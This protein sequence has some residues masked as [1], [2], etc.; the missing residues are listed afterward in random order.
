MVELN[1]SERQPRSRG[2]AMV[3]Y[4]LILVLLALAFGIAIA[5]TGPAIGNV[6]CNVVHNL[7]GNSASPQGGECGSTAPDLIAEGGNPPLFWAT[8]TWVAGHPQGETPFPTPI[9]R[10]ASG[11]SGSLPTNTPSLTFTPS[12]T[13]T[14]TPSY[15]PTNTPTPTDSATPGPSPTNGDIAFSLPHV[16]QVS[17]PEWWR[18]DS[19]D[20]TGYY[21]WSV[22]WYD[23]MSVSLNAGGWQN[24][25]LSSP[26][27]SDS[28]LSYD[29]NGI[30]FDWGTGIPSGSGL[31]GNNTW[32]GDFN[33]TL[34]VAQTALYQFDL[35]ANDYANVYIDGGNP[36]VWRASTGSASATVA[37]NAGTHNLRILYADNSGSA[38]LALTVT[39]LTVNPDDPTSNPTTCTWGRT[40]GSND[41]V[42]VSWQ[43]DENPASDSWPGGQTCYLELRGYVDLM[44]DLNP[45]LSFW[46][47]W[48][49]AAGSGV[50]VDLQIGN[51]ETDAFGFLDRS[52]LN[53]QT[54][55]LHGAGTS[56]YNWTREQIDIRSAAPPLTNDWVTFRFRI[57]SGAG[58]TPVRWYIDDLQL[59]NDPAPTTTFTV[60]DTWDL[61]SSDQMDDFIFDGDSN[62]TIAA[63][64]SLPNTT[65]SWRWDL[66]STHAHSG[67]SW[68]DSPTGNYQDHSQAASGQQRVHYLE[69]KY[70]IDLTSPPLTD[71]DGD[72]GVPL[73]TFW[74]AFDIALNAS[75]RVQ[76]T[77]D[78]N[79]STPD[80][81]I[82]VPAEGVLIDY[83][84]PTGSNRTNMV[85][86][87][88]EIDLTNITNL[89]ITNFRLRFAL[90]VDGA[91]TAFAD[92]WYIDDIKIERENP[93]PFFAYPF[94]DDAENSVDTAEWWEAIGGEW[95]AT[96]ERGGAN[97]SPT[98]YADSPLANYDPNDTQILQLH[99]A[100][101]LLNDTPGNTSGGTAATSPLLTFWHQ[102]NVQ[103]GVTFSVDL[104]TPGD[105]WNQIWLYDSAT[106][107][108]F[109]TQS[110]WERVEI[111][112]I[113]AL[114]TVTG[115][116]WANIVAN[117]DSITDDDDIKVRFVFAPGSATPSDGV[118]VDEINIK[119]APGMEHRLWAVASGGNGALVDSIESSTNFAGPWQLRWYHGGTWG[120]TS[121][122]GYTRTGSQALTD[123]PPA[124]STNYSANTF[125]VM[126]LIPIIDMTSTAAGS[127][128][129][130]SFWTRYQIGSDDTFRVEIAT[131]NAA[132]TT[133]SYNK[134]GG[135]SAW[136]AQPVMLDNTASDP[137]TNTEVDTW[138]RGQVDLT[139]FIGQKIRVRIVANVPNTTNQADGIYVDEVAFTYSPRLI[140]LPYAETGQSLVNWISEGTWGLAQNYYPGTGTSASDFGSTSWV[141]TYFDC[142]NLG[143]SS[144]NSTST[145][146]QML[147]DQTNLAPVAPFNS[148][149][150]TQPIGPEILADINFDWG[151]TGRPLGGA[152]PDP[153]FANT[154]LARWTRTVTLSPGTYS[155]STVSDD[156]VNLWIDDFTDTDIIGSSAAASGGGAN[157]RYIIN[158][159][160]DHS[161]ALDYGSFTVTNTIT[162]VLTLE[163][164]ENG[165]SAKIILNATRGSYSFTDSPNTPYTACSPNDGD[166]C[167][168]GLTVVK[169][170]Y[171]GNSSL[172][173]N[174]Y[175]SLPVSGTPSLAY[176][177]L[178]QLPANN[179]FYVEV[180]TDGG[181]TWTTIGSET[182]SGTTRLPPG[183]YWEQR[184]VSLSAYSGQAHM[185]IRFRLDTRGSGGTT[186]DGVYVADIRVTG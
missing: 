70:P 5:A 67:L 165:G 87:P 24:I 20:F 153:A 12:E 92:G 138:Q 121:T 79:D 35:T 125:S 179:F 76:Y 166:T 89:G 18:L 139:S 100:I 25:T 94:V 168:N 69:F 109:R 32:G 101:D 93:S 98:A 180:S 51:Y 132:S 75:I 151:T 133:Q 162:R 38:N 184:T 47:I 174:G 14:T 48:D 30:N 108:S 82:D 146:S 159:W 172:M 119:D 73:L 44:G 7:G 96:T 126:E 164:Y 27:N 80:N 167:I 26:R 52:Q 60:G 63:N 34:E 114:E 40:S 39:R 16:D 4:A 61:D 15:T 3:E 173:M 78:A 130:M 9:R 97:S 56:N 88:V 50:S 65:E 124:P 112:L 182:L 83:T 154:F 36:I 186:A 105:G 57:S 106:D 13:P 45:L 171:R 62:R 110:A 21:P 107:T 91:A 43:F 42:S 46:E 59:I 111:N 68:D 135:W 131:Q 84:T 157:S 86:H 136:T 19:G 140:T 81:W 90:Y 23:G 58:G 115:K 137:M 10:P 104:W 2:Q 71:G 143:Y 116:T 127:Y 8:V 122:A 113:S 145:Y 72:T 55:N 175:F 6:F 41:P 177:R 66:T 170:V 103:S 155:F 33:R 17:N 28:A 123:S 158:H 129:M 22:D 142:E 11:G 150:P 102:R 95:G 144:C 74:Q 37:L 120:T 169:S 163:F 147:L 49:L 134:I 178:Y 185:M 54:I 77:T 31:G 128:P 181:F 149:D 152:A 183:N 160:G 85:M 117:G 118:Y 1:T 141:G 156:G 99:Y 29:I 148:T 161:A 53:W 64:P 176:Q